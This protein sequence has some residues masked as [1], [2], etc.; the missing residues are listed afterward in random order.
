MIYDSSK[1]SCGVDCFCEQ[2]ATEQNNYI[3]NGYTLM[4]QLTK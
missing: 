3:P 1:E 2:S 4:E